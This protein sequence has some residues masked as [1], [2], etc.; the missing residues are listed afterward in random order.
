M[1]DGMDLWTMLAGKKTTMVQPHE[2]LPGRTTPVLA[3]PFFHRVFGDPIDREVSGTE[4]AYFAMGCFWGAER[5]FWNTEGV[6]LTSVGYA[7]GFTPNPTYVEACSGR[8][9]HT[10]TVRVSYDPDVVS[11]AELVKIFF[12][13]HD[14]TQSMR[15]GNDVGTQYRSAIFTTTQDQLDQARALAEQ[16]QPEFTR[17]GF[18]AIT[19]QIEPAGPWYFAEAEH[20]QYLEDNPGGYCNHG[21][22]GVSCQVGVLPN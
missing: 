6:R 15:Q 4:V 1:V 5:I 13:N 22:N 19:T 18:G 10:E 11:F 14:P 21:P 3:M 20:Q 8:T 16:W 17:A 9:G 12:E 7:G 2:A